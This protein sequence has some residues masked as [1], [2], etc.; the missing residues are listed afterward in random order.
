MAAAAS[1]DCKSDKRPDA[2]RRLDQTDKEEIVV[3]RVDRLEIE[4][5]VTVTPVDHAL[6]KKWES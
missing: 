6:I 1:R 5:H 2:T 3:V 4:R